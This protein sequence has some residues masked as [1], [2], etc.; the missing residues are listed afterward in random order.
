M[1][2]STLSHY[3]IVEKLGEGGMGL[4]YK[5]RDKRLDRYVALK[6]LPARAV[7]DPGRKYRFVQEA[8]SASALNHP[9]IITVYD[10]DT[11][12]AVS[13]IAMEFVDGETL[14]TLIERA[15][16]AQLP[17]EEALK[18]A[19]QL[20]EALETAHTAGLIHRDIKPRNI[21][22]TRKGLVKV[23]D[24]GLAKLTEP[25]P[26]TDELKDTTESVSQLQTEE[27]TILGTVRYMSPEQAQ[28]ARIDTRSDIFSFGTVLYE[29]LTGRHPFPG[30]TRMATMASIL[31]LEPKP[32]C[33]L[34]PGLPS[35]LERVILRCLRKDPA[36]RFHH[37]ADLRVAL[38]EVLQEASGGS[39]PAQASGQSW[40]QHKKNVTLMLAGAA[41]AAVLVGA[42]TFAFRAGQDADSQTPS[43]VAPLTSYR[44][45]ERHPSFSPDGTQ[46]AFAWSGEEGEIFDI[47]VK[48]VDGGS[49]LRL[50]TGPES[51]LYPAWSPD[52]RQIAFVRG[53]SVWLV[54]PLG[55]AERKLTDAARFP[56]SWTP[57]SRA[58]TIT[59]RAAPGEPYRVF[60]VNLADG[61]RQPLTDPPATA[62][63]DEEARLSPD[64]KTLAFIRWENTTMADLHVASVDGDGRVRRLTGDRRGIRGFAWTRDGSEI[65]FASRRGGDQSLWRVPVSGGEPRRLAGVGEFVSYP[66]ISHSA[67][68]PPRLAFQRTEEDINIWR[69]ALGE[70][71]KQGPAPARF[72]ASTRLDANPQ[73][74]PDGSRV[75]FLSDQ[76]GLDEIWIS[77]AEGASLQQLTSLNTGHLGSPRWSPDGRFIVFDSVATGNGDIYVATVEG[78][79]PRRLTPE[80]SREGRPSWSRD[81]R[82]IYF[83]SDRSGSH[84]IW[85]MPSEGGEAVQV[86]RGGGF[87][88]FESFDAS[89]VYY[90]KSRD[91][92][93]LWSVP[94]DGGEEMLVLEAVP[95]GYWSLHKDG[96]YYLDVNSG[97]G[98]TPKPVRYYSFATRQHTD[99]GVQRRPIPLRTPGFTV[100]SDGRWMLCAQFDYRDTDLML[101]E[102]FH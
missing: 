13:Y 47:Y 21:M 76:G 80:E 31:T 101:I 64:G 65:V 55:G 69:M 16:G 38:E 50:T 7:A 22:V 102:N 61:S 33:E 48:L 93:G 75:A 35:E 89:K 56:I 45:E 77:D 34:R 41:L 42:I 3:E 85:K 28:G 10:I 91:E 49:P 9:N 78:G 52:G 12:G 51:D 11:A 60:L 27:G 71:R 25:V 92:L 87:E 20:A 74:S 62:Q 70:Y 79:P 4:V 83:R 81:G 97:T 53:E 40:R 72:L 66:A 63:G 84:Q 58:I 73:Y 54:S 15:A 88:A 95:Q 90:I 59:D 24:F 68:V 14:D 8:R 30:E 17:V 96:V 39:A 46:V 19:I 2:G 23:L 94:P 32:P 100:S 37:M 36:R 98:N 44:G 67:S 5:A 86:T 43:R 18:Y 29:M 57:D 99:L 6:V 26:S 82:W 1:I